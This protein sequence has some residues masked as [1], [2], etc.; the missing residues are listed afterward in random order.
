MTK[1]EANRILQTRD[2]Y[3]KRYVNATQDIDVIDESTYILIITQMPLQDIIKVILFDVNQKIKEHKNR[4][5]YRRMYKSWIK[6]LLLVC[7]KHQLPIPE[8]FEN[9]E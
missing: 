8:G 2:Q 7:K 1:N 6:L 3:Q 4:D 9:D 5:F